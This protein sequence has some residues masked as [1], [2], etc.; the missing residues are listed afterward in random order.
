M[1]PAHKAA[2]LATLCCPLLAH[3]QS[4]QDEL[5]LPRTDGA[6]IVIK[7]RYD[8]MW[9]PGGAEP[10]RDTVGVFLVGD[11]GRVHTAYFCHAGRC[12]G[13]ESYQ[14]QDGM[15]VRK[16]G[17]TSLSLHSPFAR[18]A[19]HR[20]RLAFEKT[21]RYRD[22]KKV[23]MKCSAGPD[24]TPTLETSYHYDRQGRLVSEHNSY[25]PQSAV[26]YPTHYDEVSYAYEGDSVFREC[27]EGGE[28]RD[29][30][31]WLAR[32]DAQQ[33]L[34][35]RA[36]RSADGSHFT[37]ERFQ[38]DSLGHLRV[39]ICMRDISPLRE[40]GSVAYPDRIER[41]FDERGRLISERFFAREI[42]RW[43]FQYTYIE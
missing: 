43:E 40:D 18:S 16:T 7:V 4:P 38:Y 13:K 25:P 17:Y 14:Y 10:E 21:W 35:E 9:K 37:H 20:H 29:S 32:L 27:F 42:K 15:L 22:G 33:R 5:P 12:T 19:Q 30:S 28:L 31:R 2:F 8:F 6:C 3:G 41:V 11:D 36:E 1:L 39:F 34:I 23:S 24:R 26:Q